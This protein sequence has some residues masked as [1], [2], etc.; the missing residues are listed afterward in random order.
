MPNEFARDIKNYLKDDGGVWGHL[1]IFRLSVFIDINTILL[2]A[3]SK[4]YRQR[5][6]TVSPRCTGRN[7]NMS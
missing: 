5:P 7:R 4:L 2:M 3:N 6:R 1:Q